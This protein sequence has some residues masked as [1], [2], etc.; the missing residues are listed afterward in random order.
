MP[1]P[2]KLLLLDFFNLAWV[3][4]ALGLF[5]YF[6]IRRSNPLIR[7]HEHGN[8]WTYPFNFLDLVVMVVILGS[9][10][11]MISTSATSD[12][13]PPDLDE[14]G[15]VP[16]V[17]TQIITMS[18][19][20][21]GI[22]F[23]LSYARRI[24]VMEL[25]GLKRLRLTHV[26]LWTVGILAVSIPLIGLAAVGWNQWLEHAFGIE[27]EKQEL[28]TTM[29]QTEDLPV[30]LLMAFSACIVAPLTE[31]VLFRGYFYPALKRHSERFFAA[32]V[33]SLLFAVIHNNTSSIVP[34]FFFAMALTLAYELTGCLLVPI[35]M[36]AIFNTVQVVLIFTLST[37]G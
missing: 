21:T 31:E 6:L 12:K 3:M 30:K 34:L 14:I 4:L 24:D 25:F 11:A 9:Y 18:V 26:V 27:P 37:N 23:V 29:M 28:V 36:H 19:L 33:I 22:V 35:A 20:I 16:I 17:L 13:P 8:V 1:D 5:V 15:I 10:Y 2:T 7:W 32:V